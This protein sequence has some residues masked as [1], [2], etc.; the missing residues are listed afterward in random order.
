V[1]ASDCWRDLADAI[2]CHDV[3]RERH[4]WVECLAE[5][6]PPIAVVVPVPVS[7]RKRGAA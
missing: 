5:E 6:K 7:L 4:A 2:C 3:D 1:T